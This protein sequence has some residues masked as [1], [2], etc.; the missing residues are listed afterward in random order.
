M[1][2]RGGGRIWPN[3]VINFLSKG[4]SFDGPLA[5]YDA[6]MGKPEEPTRFIG[7]QMNEYHRIMLGPEPGSTFAIAMRVT[8][9]PSMRIED[10]GLQEEETNT[11]EETQEEE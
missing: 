5:T 8:Y 1:G 7:L 2:F 6:F 3:I 11:E 9:P 10:K 4:Y